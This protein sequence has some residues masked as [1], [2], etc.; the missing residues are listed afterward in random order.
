MLQMMAMISFMVGFIRI[1]IQIAEQNPDRMY[2]IVGSVV[3][4]DN[5]VSL[6]FND[7]KTHIAEWQT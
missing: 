6:N 3:D 2:G 1:P 4:L 7:H 5:V